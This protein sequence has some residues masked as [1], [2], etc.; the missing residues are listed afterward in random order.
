MLPSKNR[1]S[2][3]DVAVEMGRLRSSHANGRLIRERMA[4][5]FK[6]YD[7]SYEDEGHGCT[8]CQKDIWYMVEC[9]TP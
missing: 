8:N 2:G 5:G 6:V 3:S 7:L 1:D 9:S 4:S